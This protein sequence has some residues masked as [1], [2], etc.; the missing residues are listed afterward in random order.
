[1]SITNIS[2]VILYER[3]TN[4]SSN[5]L[6]DNNACTKIMK[7]LL[8]IVGLYNVHTSALPLAY[9]S[10]FLKVSNIYLCILLKTEKVGGFF[11][12]K[13][14]M[15]FHFPKDNN[16]GSSEKVKQ[17]RKKAQLIQQHLRT[18]WKIWAPKAGLLG[19]SKYCLKETR[20]KCR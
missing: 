4:I 15:E 5:N 6:I 10:I 13:A 8:R 1:M 14:H 3:M 17:S 2:T 20:Q 16:T 12:E 18:M 7:V 9:C 19:D 11:K